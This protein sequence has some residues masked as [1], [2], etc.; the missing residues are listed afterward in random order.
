MHFCPCK[1]N[2]PRSIPIHAGSPVTMVLQEQYSNIK[3]FQV[4]LIY[5]PNLNRNTI[6]IK[7]LLYY[8]Y[9]IIYNSKLQCQR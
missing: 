7:I 3:V 4:C 2:R 6:F 5:S 1:P 8:I 9:C